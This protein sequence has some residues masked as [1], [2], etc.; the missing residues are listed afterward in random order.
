MTQWL[1]AVL[2]EHLLD[3]L[4]HLVLQFPDALFINRVCWI[5]HRRMNWLGTLVIWLCRWIC[6]CCRGNPLTKLGQDLVN[7]GCGERAIPS[8]LQWKGNKLNPGTY[9]GCVTFHYT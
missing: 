2:N 4:G 6:D 5:S 3:E 7:A 1:S 8:K 9:N